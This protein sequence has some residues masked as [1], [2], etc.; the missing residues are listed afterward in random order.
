MNAECA[1]FGGGS[2][3]A[4]YTAHVWA[5]RRTLQCTCRQRVIPSVQGTCSAFIYGQVCC[6]TLQ[7]ALT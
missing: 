6:L 3:S 5:S 2:S 7:D 1:G 4:P